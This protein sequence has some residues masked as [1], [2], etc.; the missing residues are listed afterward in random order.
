MFNKRTLHKPDKVVIIVHKP[1]SYSIMQ[2]PLNS[3]Q[4]VFMSKW[5]AQVTV[6]LVLCD[7]QIYTAIFVAHAG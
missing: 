2:T 5:R 7:S 3:H 1:G 4:S 6:D